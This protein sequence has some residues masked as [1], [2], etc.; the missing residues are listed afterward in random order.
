MSALSVS[1]LDLPLRLDRGAGAPLQQQLLAQLRAA[2][3]GGQLAGGTR[4]PSSRT[5]ATALGVSR[6]VVVGVYDELFAEGY[7]TGRHGSGTYVEDTLPAAPHRAP[8]MPTTA[9]RWLRGEPLP[10]AVGTPFADDVPGLISFRPGVPAIELLPPAVWRRVWREVGETPPP[11][12]YADA[13]GDPELRLALARWV[14]RTRGIPCDADDV[15]VT[16]GAAQALDLLARAILA[17]GDAVAFEEPGYPTGRNILLAHGARVLPIPVDEDGLRVE[18]LPTGAD[19][20]LLACV[21]PSHQ[22]PLGAR[23]PIARRLALLDWARTNDSLIVEDDYDSEFRFDAPPLPAL[24]SLDGEKGEGRVAYIGTFAKSLAPSLRLGY[25]IV[26]PALRSRI[27]GL[28]NLADRHTSWPIQRVVLTLI[29][30]GHLERHIRRARRRYAE[31]RAILRAGL[32]PVT[33]GP[34]APARLRGLDAGLHVCL[35]LAPQIDQARLVALARRRGVAVATLE[36]YYYGSPDR[37]GLVLGY[38]GLS[39]AD[40]ERGTRVLAK[41]IAE[42]WVARAED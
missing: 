26:P 1:Q 28:K 29:A 15:V 8:A 5:L 33:S 12:R 17:P 37:Q 27:V 39:P 2:I 3:S 41:A 11:K 19:A 34:D 31:D 18:M 21:T 36:D 14:G 40:L 42:C 38:G 9:R 35:E 16:T 13:A 32:A 22:Y 23:L 25:L 20:P 24:M 30:E 7:V 6:N 4:L 10:T